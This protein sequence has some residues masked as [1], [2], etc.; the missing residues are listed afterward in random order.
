[1]LIGTDTVHPGFLLLWFHLIETFRN[2]IIV[3]ALLKIVGVGE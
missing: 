3:Y 1:M 2:S